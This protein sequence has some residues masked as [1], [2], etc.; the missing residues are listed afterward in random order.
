MRS[1]FD[2][3]EAPGWGSQDGRTTDFTENTEAEESP[4]MTQIYTDEE[5]LLYV[6]VFI[7]DI[8]G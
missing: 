1:S 5:K 6:S 7:C 4:Q 2:A 8:C 3:G